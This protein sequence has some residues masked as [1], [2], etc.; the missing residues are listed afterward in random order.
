MRLLRGYNSETQDSIHFLITDYNRYSRFS[1]FAD[2]YK[3]ELL[4]DN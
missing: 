2:A 4:R 1:D 3:D